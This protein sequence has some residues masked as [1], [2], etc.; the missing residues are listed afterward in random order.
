MLNWLRR[1]RLSA[2]ARRKLLIVAARSEEAIVETHVSNALDLLEALGDEVDLEH[3][4]ELYREMIPI[5][6]S[7]ASIVM[8]RI[9]AR[10]EALPDQGGKGSRSARFRDVFREGG[11]DR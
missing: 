7:M 5:G 3:G 6:D 11:A 2:N 1:P 8:N 10:L 9:L 4:L